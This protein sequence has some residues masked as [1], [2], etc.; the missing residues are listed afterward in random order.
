MSQSRLI[1]ISDERSVN[2]WPWADLLPIS[3]KKGDPDRMCA[4]RWINHAN[5][6]KLFGDYKSQWGQDSTKNQG[7]KHKIFLPIAI[8]ICTHLCRALQINC[9]VIYPISTLLLQKLRQLCHPEIK[10]HNTAKRPE[11]YPL[12]PDN[13]LTPAAN[14]YKAGGGAE[15]EM[16]MWGD[17]HDDTVLT[18]VFLFSNF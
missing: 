11:Q 15:V 6:F 10:T 5:T 2:V 9:N 3:R 7:V 4:T 16:Q 14:E 8:R 1:Y 12:N 13:S 18:V 17:A